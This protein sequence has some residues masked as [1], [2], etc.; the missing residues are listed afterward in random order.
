MPE[1]DTWKLTL[2]LPPGQPLTSIRID[3]FPKPKGG[4]WNDKNVVLNELKVE[5]IEPGQDP[6]PCKLVRPRADF[7]QR[8]WPVC[9][10]D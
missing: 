3:T 7:S 5:L 9:Q 6:V 2:Q 1:K 4:K 8:D 10:G